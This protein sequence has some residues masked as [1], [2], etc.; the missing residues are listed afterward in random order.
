MSHPLFRFFGSVGR[1]AGGQGKRR[2]VGRRLKLEHLED[3]SVPA[4]SA[5]NF[6]VRVNSTTA[7]QQDMAQAAVDADGDSVVVWLSNGQDGD[8]VGVFAQRY[9]AD[10]A[11]LGGEFQVNAFTTGPHTK[12]SV[13][14]DADGDFV[15]AWSS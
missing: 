5:V 3:R 11:R 4:F 2:A 6:E 8:S 12:P 15:V 1:S 13:A 9:D 14:V 10:G 7:G